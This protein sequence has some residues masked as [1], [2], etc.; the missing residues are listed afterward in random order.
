MC[1]IWREP[2]RTCAQNRMKWRW[3]AGIV[4]ALYLSVGTVVAATH[5]HSGDALHGDQQ[6][7]ACAWHHEAIDAPTVGP[8]VSAPEWVLVAHQ[9]DFL[10]FSDVS[11]GIHPSRGPP[12]FPQ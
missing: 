2:S 1:L 12:L 8:G 7:A 6:C 11:V 4:C 3:I 9:A 5:D 10:H